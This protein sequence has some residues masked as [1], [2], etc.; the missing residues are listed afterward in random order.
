ML[1]PIVELIVLS[2]F[3]T[4]AARRIALAADAAD[5]GPCMSPLS[6]M[7]EFYDLDVDP[8]VVSVG[9]EVVALWHSR[10]AGRLMPCWRDFDMPDF[11]KWIGYVC[12]DDVTCRSP[13]DTTT[14]LWGS[15]MTALTGSDWTGTSIRDDAAL[16][17][18]TEGDFDFWDRIVN[19]PSIA[20]TSGTI[21]WLNRDFV[22]L[23]RIFL[24][25]SDGGGQVD[26]VVS[27]AFPQEARR[28]LPSL[29]RLSVRSSWRED[30]L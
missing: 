4:C 29:D 30:A 17:G 23:S 20:I 8:D 2:P 24:P 22:R 11:V 1:A 21:E 6:W 27:V 12:C 26:Q 18:M 25:L 7:Q 9:S 13:I 19:G 15:K 3:R 28:Q 16:R 10:R 14:R 5:L